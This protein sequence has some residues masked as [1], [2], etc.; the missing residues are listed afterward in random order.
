ML[1]GKNANHFSVVLLYYNHPE[2]SPERGGAMRTHTFED[3]WR[4]LQRELHPQTEVRNWTVL[5]GYLGDSMKIVAVRA[6]T[7]EVDAP[8]AR[9]LVVVP[10]A[11]FKAV[12]RLGDL[13]PVH[14]WP[15]TARRAYKNDLF[16]E[17]H[18]QCSALAGNGRCLSNL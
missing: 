18:H 5:K 15:G 9:N 16:L 13:E 12:H 11:H 6:E 4:Q 17:V 3:V 7:I 14:R 8:R 10:K 2:F 1:F